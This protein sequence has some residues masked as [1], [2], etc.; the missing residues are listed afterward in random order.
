MLKKVKILEQYNGCITYDCDTIYYIRLNKGAI[1]SNHVH[2]DQE[3]VFLM[4]G[5]AELILGDKI[6]NV[7][8][9]IKITIPPKMYHKFTALTDLVGLEIR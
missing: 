9:P 3:I 7:K 5:E 4:E 6:Q 8:A 1:A 2:D